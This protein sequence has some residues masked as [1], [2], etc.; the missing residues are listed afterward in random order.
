MTIVPDPAAPQD[1]ARSMGGLL[2][3]AP[4]SLTVIEMVGRAAR[5]ASR[6]TGGLEVLGGPVLGGKASPGR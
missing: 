2:R 1:V 4:S 6:A 5:L 3:L